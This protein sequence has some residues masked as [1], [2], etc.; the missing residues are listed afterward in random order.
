MINNYNHLVNKLLLNH[1]DIHI[2]VF[3]F[4]EIP[5][6]IAIR[7]NS[8]GLIN[9]LISEIESYSSTITFDEE[10]ERAIICNYRGERAK[11]SVP[12]GKILLGKINLT[13]EG[14][15]L[16]KLI[17]SEKKQN[18]LEYIFKQYPESE[19]EIL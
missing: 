3:D 9:A 19:I 15:I 8:I 16:Q 11:I 10:E 14:E 17:V 6:N 1:L 18:M 2:Q 4:K 12:D 13:Q 5:L 7:L